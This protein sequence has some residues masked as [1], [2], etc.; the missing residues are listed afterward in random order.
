[1][2]L[3]A[4]AMPGIGSTLKGTNMIDYDSLPNHG[5]LEAE[6]MPALELQ[7]VLFRRNYGMRHDADPYWRRLHRQFARQALREL[8][9]LTNRKSKKVNVPSGYGQQGL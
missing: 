5:P 7:T 1:M 9:Y 8:R 6:R 2:P 3:F 4:G